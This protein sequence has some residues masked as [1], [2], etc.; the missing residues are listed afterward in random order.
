MNQT[1]ASTQKATSDEERKGGEPGFYLSILITAGAIV[2][3]AA[4]TSKIITVDNTTLA[5]VV[6]GLLPW[7]LP[8]LAQFVKEIS[9]AGISLKIQDQVQR[10]VREEVE[11][12]KQTVAKHAE[13]VAQQAESVAQQS[14]LATGLSVSVAAAPAP[15]AASST[16]Q[17]PTQGALE[18]L[19]RLVDR[20]HHIRDTQA[21]S[22]ERTR[23]M[24]AVVGEMVALS[25]KVTGL[26][27]K[28][29]LA[30]PITAE[31]D[32][33]RLVGY[34]YLYARPDCSVLNDLV[35]SVR[36]EDVTP[37]GQYWGIQAIGETVQRC[38]VADL[39]GSTMAKL[40]A[41]RDQ[42]GRE[43]DRYNYVSDVL[44]SLERK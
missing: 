11:P 29:Y 8:W 20:Y 34:A 25:H 36:H 2:V 17:F 12:L 9:F 43:T 40:Y 26:D 37:F 5:I 13:A 24:A 19:D 15:V 4:H 1:Q 27:F 22:Y 23:Q 21:G 7:S 39:D 16:A 41:F 33:K 6:L 14:G 3:A 31:H 32:G 44:R 30:A 35:D 42:L 18:Q 10:A 38:A 28:S